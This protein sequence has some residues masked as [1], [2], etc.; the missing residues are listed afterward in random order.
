MI[1]TMLY[2]NRVRRY[3]VLATVMTLVV[4]A[5]AQAKQIGLDVAVGT[6]VL[7]AG[8]K[9]TAYLRVAM[10]GFDMDGPS[11]GTPVNVAIVLDKSGSMQG[12]KLARAKEAAILAISRLN[13]N[14]IVSVVTYDSTVN[15][16]AP[17][18]KL[19]DRGV[20]IDE[21]RGIEAGSNTALFAGVSKGAAE[22]HK[23]LSEDRVN[24]VIL[25][26]DGLANVGPNSPGALRDLGASFAK[27]G[28]AVTTIGLG[29]GYNEDLMTQLAQASDGNHMFAENAQDL[30]MAFN[31]EFNDV[32]SVVAQD[33]AVRIVCPKGVRPVRVLG[34]EADIVGQTVT[35]RLNQ[36]YSDQTKYVVLEVEVPASGP[37]T[38]MHVASVDLTYANMETKAMDRLASS[39]SVAFSASPAEIEAKLNKDVMAS[40]VRL[41]GAERNMFATRLR[42][43]GRIEEAR[44]TL[45][46]NNIFLTEQA[47]RLGNEDL[48]RD[49]ADNFE[50]SSNLDDAN[51]GRQRKVMRMNQNVLTQQQGNVMK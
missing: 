15:V 34:R 39:V 46:D 33:V 44:K 32:L 35:A 17:A 9:Q 12:E 36:L 24:R 16:L 21:I 14:D 45:A 26:S 40:A 5:G 27:E 3:A 43:E 7:Q 38:T 41:L 49:A 6:P 25:L 48:R 50:D 10:T 1:T 28:I 23:F 2:R 13:S 37:E 8:E 19:S 4:A 11:R 30:E 29:L 18:S 22:V 31:A 20:I 42:D 47:D 51:W